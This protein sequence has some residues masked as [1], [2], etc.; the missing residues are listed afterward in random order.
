MDQALMRIHTGIC[1]QENAVLEAPQLSLRATLPPTAANLRHHRH[2]QAMT[3]KSA[4]CKAVWERDA[5]S[6]FPSQAAV[7]NPLARLCF[8]PHGVEYSNL[9]IP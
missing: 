9:S 2:F 4:H 5:H 6:D 3:K 7:A 1:V 8:S